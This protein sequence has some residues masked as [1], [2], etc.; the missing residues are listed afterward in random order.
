MACYETRMVLYTTVVVTAVKH[1]RRKMY[2]IGVDLYSN[3][4]LCYFAY[5]KGLGVHLL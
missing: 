2:Y 5:Y 4:V 1:K 3:C